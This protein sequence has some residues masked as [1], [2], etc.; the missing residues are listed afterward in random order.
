LLN[1]QLN[2]DL[3]KF[4]GKPVLELP[5]FDQL[6]GLF[7]AA[8]ADGELVLEFWRDGTLK[9]SQRIDASQLSAFGGV[10]EM[11]KPVYWAR[12]IARFFHVTPVLPPD[13][14]SIPPIDISH[15]Y[16]LITAGEYRL[17]GEVAT[18][19][20]TVAKASGI[21]TDQQRGVHLDLGETRISYRIYDV[22]VQVDNVNTSLTSGLFDR[23]E[24]HADS[25]SVVVTIRAAQGGEWVFRK[26]F[27][28]NE[29][30]SG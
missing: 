18:V 7:G 8:A 11:L 28:L 21:E 13:F 3:S 25:D 15:L 17:P 10:Y 12:E 20:A 14:D 4:D 30:S 1:C 24:S 6:F 16:K 29:E 5:Y 26:K 23:I 2:L 19:T 27:D 9:V 22:T